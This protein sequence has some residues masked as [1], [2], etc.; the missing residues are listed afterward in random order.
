MSDLHEQIGQLAASVSELCATLDGRAIGQQTCRVLA[1]AK[2]G[3]SAA[4][5]ML[6]QIDGHAAGQ[7]AARTLAYAL[8]QLGQS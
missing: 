8:G 4:A 5:R 6:G 1:D 7:A 3:A 2:A